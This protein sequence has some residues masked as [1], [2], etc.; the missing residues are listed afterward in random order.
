VRAIF[1]SSVLILTKTTNELVAYFDQ[2]ELSPHSSN[3]FEMFRTVAC[4]R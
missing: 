1:I 4:I 2:G 3:T